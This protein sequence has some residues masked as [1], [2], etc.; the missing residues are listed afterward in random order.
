MSRFR[1]LQERQKGCDCLKQLWK[2]IP[3]VLLLGMTACVPTPEEEIVVYRGDDTIEQRLSATAA[4]DEETDFEPPFPD[5]W[6]ME[7]YDVNDRCR[8]EI[9]AE[10][11]QKADAG[12]PVYRTHAYA[13]TDEDIQAYAE[14]L[15]PKPVSVH[16]AEMTKEDWTRMFREF[17]NEVESFQAW[18]AAGRPQDGIDRDE[19]GYPQSFVD[20]ESKW[21]MEQIQNAPDT[22][23]ETPVSDYQGLSNGDS[24]VF[25][26]ENGRTAHV[27]AFDWQIAV[28]LDCVEQGY[29]YDVDRYTWEQRFDD[30]GSPDAWRPVSMER[31]EADRLLK[32]ALERLNMTDFSVRLAREANL[33]EEIGGKPHSVA[34][35]WAYELVRDYGGYPL[36]SV[37]FEPDQ[38]IAYGADDGFQANRWIG[39][40][41]LQIMIGPNGVQ[42]FTYTSPKTVAGLESANAALLPWN[43]AEMRIRNAIAVTVPTQSFIEHDTV[44]TMRVYR[45]LLTTYTVRVRNSEDCYEMPCWVVFYDKDIRSRSNLA[46]YDEL[47]PADFWEKQ[48]ENTI[49][50]H[51]VLIVNAVDGSIIY[52][53]Y[54]R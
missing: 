5:R 25:R 11:V 39:K 16:T 13:F 41:T 14:A 28:S 30:L 31:N 43:E 23:P 1:L 32:T 2:C 12:Y 49:V 46:I 42:S 51:S 22:L 35:G 40:E 18:E 44:C 37:E 20:S 7:G 15:L 24:K 6:A 8:V 50:T 54:G 38:N 4:P 9:D 47:Y 48:R 52:T 26:L 34:T 36:S 33:M 45:L 10:I 19:S 3:L 53:D 29:V 17:L 27:A 21:Y